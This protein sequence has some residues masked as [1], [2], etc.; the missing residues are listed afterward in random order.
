MIAV[1]GWFNSCANVDAIVPSAETREIWISSLLSCCLSCSDWRSAVSF[2]AFRLKAPSAIKIT[3]APQ[4]C[5]R[6]SV[7]FSFE[8]TSEKSI[9]TM[10]ACLLSSTRS[11]ERSVGRECVS[12]CRSRWATYHDKK[13]HNKHMWNKKTNTYTNIK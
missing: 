12:T 9:S 6:N 3:P 10:R 2:S 4:G 11:D 8:G 7:N 1:K 13:K 5:T